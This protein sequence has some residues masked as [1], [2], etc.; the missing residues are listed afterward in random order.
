MTD[1]Y[2]V[3]CACGRGGQPGRIIAWIDDRRPHAEHVSIASN[4][5]FTKGLRGMQTKRGSWYSYTL[6]C[7]GCGKKLDPKNPLSEVRADEIIDYLKPQRFILDCRPIPALNQPDR[8]SEEQRAADQ[9][10]AD[11]LIDDFLAGR[12]PAVRLGN[13]DAGPFDAYESRYV[14]PFA[15][16]LSVN[17]RLGARGRS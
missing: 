17:S 9:A 16:F 14:V 10:R 7:R 4:T 15:V 1:L 5:G 8:R 3:V 6:C 12:V 13:P 2:V 11:N